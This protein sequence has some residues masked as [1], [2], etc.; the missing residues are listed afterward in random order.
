MASYSGYIQDLA[1]WWH[2]NVDKSW[3]SYREEAMRILQAED[4]LKNIVK[5]VGPEALP[6][7][8]RL[9][10]ET[11]RII[12]IAFLQQN[13][14]DAIDTYTSPQKQ[15]KMLKIIVDYHR[16]ADNVV[17]KGAPISKV[18]EMQITEEILRMKTS[19]PNEKCDLLDDL[20]KRMYESFGML[21][22]TLR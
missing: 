16:L 15:F 7:K 2:K 14:L 22:V 1:E 8:Q 10:L 19:T 13:A 4:D 3:N 12:R 18:A 5:L 6:D 11:A 20:E 17:S 9:I 21:E